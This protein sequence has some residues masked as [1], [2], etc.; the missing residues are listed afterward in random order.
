M[1]QITAQIKH[2][3]QSLKL[4]GAQAQTGPHCQPALYNYPYS[5]VPQDISPL[6]SNCYT[7]HN[8]MQP[9]NGSTVSTEHNDEHQP[10]HEC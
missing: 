6:T 10:V 5:S 2:I 4:W 7:F 8:N 3:S 9:R 1:N